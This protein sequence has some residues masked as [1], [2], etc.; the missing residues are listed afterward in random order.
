MTKS[1]TSNKKPSRS[2]QH[3]PRRLWCRAQHSTAQ[4]GVLPAGACLCG[5]PLRSLTPNSRPERLWVTLLKARGDISKRGLAWGSTAILSAGLGPSPYCLGRLSL[6]GCLR[7]CPRWG[8]AGKSAGTQGAG[9]TDSP[10]VS[11]PVLVG[12]EGPAS[13]QTVGPHPSKAWPEPPGGVGYG[14]A[15]FHQLK[16]KAPAWSVPARQQHKL[17]WAPGQTWAAPP[18]AGHLTSYG[19]LGKVPRSPDQV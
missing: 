9:Q 5:R 3:V 8:E 12:T 10:A 7:S 15:L 1:K 2:N 14:Q 19:V 16:S 13:G 4:G 6:T 17:L 18:W 11:S